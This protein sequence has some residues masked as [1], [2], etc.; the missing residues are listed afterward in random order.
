MDNKDKPETAIQSRARKELPPYQSKEWF[1]MPNR[2]KI[3]LI[4]QGR[5]FSRDSHDVDYAGN[6]IN[7]CLAA[8]HAGMCTYEESLEAIVLAFHQQVNTF[9]KERIDKVMLSV[10]PRIFIDP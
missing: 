1:D 4:A 2:E 6:V 8:H 10:E 3:E 5:P 7:R 9:C